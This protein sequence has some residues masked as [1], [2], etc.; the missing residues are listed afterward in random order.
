MNPVVTAV[1][2]V[3]F[4]AALLA[5]VRQWRRMRR[6]KTTCPHNQPCAEADQADLS[7]VHEQ[8]V[9]EAQERAD[10]DDFASGDADD[11][12]G[13]CPMYGLRG[14]PCTPDMYGHSSSN[15]SQEAP[16]TAL[17][18]KAAKPK[19][20]GQVVPQAGQVHEC[21][22]LGELEDAIRSNSVV[23]MYATGC[24]HCSAMKPAFES[25]A[26]QARVP[27]YAVDAVQVPE[28]VNR[29]NLAGFPTIFRFAGG[30][31]VEEY[32]GDRSAR[33]FVLFANRF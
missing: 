31:V 28:L 27:F 13:G 20:A 4:L 25:A 11:D 9:V 30:R 14:A 29:Y 12:L 26:V 19:R 33:D 21:G 10:D 5:F 24:G 15:H 2:V 8:H 1:L 23:L 16:P 32:S 3:L 7:E 18:H 6:A 22:T 17:R